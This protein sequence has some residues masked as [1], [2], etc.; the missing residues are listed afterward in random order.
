MKACI[1]RSASYVDGL[2]LHR[3]ASVEVQQ[4][5]GAT[6]LSVKILAD[7]EAAHWRQAASAS[8]AKAMN[9]LDLCLFMD[10]ASHR[11]LNFITKLRSA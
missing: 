2:G 7:T 9:F 3:G 5:Q 8:P 1:C 6:Y 4:E 10:S 11:F